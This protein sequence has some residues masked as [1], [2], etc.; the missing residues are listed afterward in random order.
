MNDNALFALLMNFVFGL[1][2]GVCLLGFGIVI[3]V[4]FFLNTFQLCC[5]DC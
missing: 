3:V 1:G 2:A 4:G 5:S